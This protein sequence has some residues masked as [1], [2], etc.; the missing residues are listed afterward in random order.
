MCDNVESDNGVNGDEMFTQLL[1]KLYARLELVKDATA[2]QSKK[3]VIPPPQLGRE[4][5]NVVWTNFE[6]TCNVLNR[7]IAHVQKF[8]DAEFCRKSSMNQENHLVIRSKYNA[9]KFEK[10]LM[11]YIAAYVKCRSCGSCRSDLDDTLI[12]CQSCNAET[13]TIVE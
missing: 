3:L 9:K 8:V 7:P 4:G 2:S 12:K 6:K 11:N 1:D 13:S 10:I 5:N